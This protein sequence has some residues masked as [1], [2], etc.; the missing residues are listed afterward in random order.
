MSLRSTTLLCTAFVLAANAADQSTSVKRGRNEGLFLCPA[1]NVM[2][3]ANLSGAI[4]ADIRINSDRL[5]SGQSVWGAIGIA[6]IMQFSAE[7]TAFDF[8]SLGPAVAHLQI[9]TPRNDKLRLFGIAASADVYLSTST[10]MLAPGTDPNKPQYSPYPLGS[11]ITDLDLIAG[12]HK[13]PMKFYLSG[14]FCDDPALLFRYR[15]IDFRFGGEWKS[16]KSSVFFETAAGLYDER[17]YTGNKGNFK[18]Y[19]V[20][21]MPGVRKRLGKR[22]SLLASIGITPF[23][24]K[25]N[26]TAS[27]KDTIGLFNPDRFSCA[28]RLEIPIVYHETNTEAVRSLEYM[29]KAT[30]KASAD[31]LT[32][33]ETAVDIEPASDTTATAK[34]DPNIATKNQAGESF[35]YKSET[36][37]LKKRRLEAQKR[38]DEIEKILEETK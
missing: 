21:L 38:M 35:D 34:K 19:R 15:Q 6:E 7:A 36:D 32:G 37:A 10:D 22:V 9:T 26:V 25:P 16:P 33:R 1:S 28:L 13:I 11:I 30:S 17:D 24:L 29:H 31:T 3:N 14:G 2:G 12:R 8:S 4:G 18:G 20:T 27:T 23:V 5:L